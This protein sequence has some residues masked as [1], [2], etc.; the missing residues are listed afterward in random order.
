MKRKKLISLLLGI[1]VIAS[2]IAA[3]TVA[4]ATAKKNELICDASFTMTSS[5]KVNVGDLTTVSVNLSEEANLG[6]ITF[7]LLYDTE[8]L[9]YVQ[10]SLKASTD[11]VPMVETNTKNPGKII[12]GGISL[13]PIMKG[14]TILTVQFKVLKP[15]C[16]VKF[17]AVEIGLG[18]FDSTDVTEQVVKNSM[19]TVTIECAHGNAE[20]EFTKEASHITDGEKRLVCTGCKETLETAVIPALGHNFDVWSVAKHPTCTEKGLEERICT[21][22][23]KESR[24]IDALG[25]DTG[26]WT[27]VLAPACTETGIQELHCTRCDTLLK[28]EEIVAVGHSFGDWK[29]VKE[30]TCTEVGTEERICTVCGE[31]ETREVAALGHDEGKWVVALAPTCT[32][33]G[34]R[35]LHCTRCDVVLKTEEIAAN[36]HSFGEWKTVK[37]ATCTGVGSEERICTV[38]GKKESREMAALGHDEGKW[39][40]TFKPTCTQKGLQELHCTRC[41][42]VLD[43]AEIDVAAHDF[44]DW[45]V[46]K[47]ATALK[48]GLQYRVCSVCSTREEEAIPKLPGEED[49]VEETTFAPST[50][51]DS[52]TKPTEPT[53]GASD[54]NE[55]VPPTGDE[56]IILPFAALAALSLGVIFITKKRKTE[57]Q[58]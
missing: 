57:R 7:N 32:E 58:S 25:H 42:T 11:I 28:T 31:K 3:T 17:E 26:K 49:T 16:T 35:E 45:V 56:T 34:T 12:Y 38:C 1:L 30:A 19:E 50:T 48:E 18:D 22:G 27:V 54:E 52:Q 6:A 33:K 15:G 47:E 43:T 23:E 51:N 24:E 44:G 13:D 29:T 21:C 5:D 46:E 41:K 55:K 4:T 40:I 37:D 20:W 14:G 8:L 10:D 36:G 53:G 39:I 2:A 9:E